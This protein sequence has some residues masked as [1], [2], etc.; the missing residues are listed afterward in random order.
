MSTDATLSDSYFG[1]RPRR[2]P[3]TL[4]LDVFSSVPLGIVLMA[5]L[6]MYC[7]IGSAGI[8]YPALGPGRW[9]PFNPDVW[10]HEMPRQWRGLELTEFEWFHTPLFNALILLICLNVIITTFRRIRLNALTAGVWM[11]HSGVVILAIGS[12]I[13]FGTKF[14]GDAPV[15]RHEVLIDVPGAPHTSLIAVPGNATHVATDAGEYEFAVASIDPAWE[16]RSESDLGKKAW[17]VMVR[18]RT[19]SAEFIRQLLAG[20]PQ[21]T[22]DVLPGRGRVKK[23]E[24]F[25]GRALVDES[26]A[27]SLGTPPQR[28]FWVKDSAAVMARDAGTLEWSQRVIH[29]LPRYNDRIA[30]MGDAWPGEDVPRPDVLDL[31][32]PGA[33][34]VLD[35]VDVR[36][37][38]YLRYAVMRSGF[39]P[40]GPVKNPVAEVRLIT[41]DGQE[42][43]ETLVAFDESRRSAFGGRM[44]FD[45]IEDPMV[46][47][48]YLDA[49]PRELILRIPDASFEQVVPFRLQDLAAAD[50][51]TVLLGETGWQYRIDKATDRLPLANGQSVTL[52]LVEFINPEGQRF[53]RWVFEDASRNRDIHPTAVEEP[54]TPALPDARLESFY[55]PGRMLSTISLVAAP[56][57]AGLHVFFDEGQGGRK[58]VTLKPGESAPVTFGVTLT[59]KRLL[60]DGME[61][62]RPMIVPRRQRDRDADA[63]QAYSLV[64]VELSK[65]GW[66][67]ARWIPFH[68][69]TFDEP[70]DPVGVLSRFEPARFT[71]PT[72]RTVEIMVGR[73]RRDLPHPVRLDDFVLT[74]HVGGFTGRVSSVR[75]WTSV[76]RFETGGA[77]SEPVRVSTNDPGMHE[78]IWFFQSFWD[79]PRAAQFEGDAPS[80]GMA[81]TGLGVGNR[82]GVYIQLFGCCLSVAGMLY[83]FYVKPIIRRRRRAHVLAE[84]EAGRLGRRPYAA[85]LDDTPIRFNGIADGD[86]TEHHR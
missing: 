33:G 60:V 85:S 58:A 6:F 46:L 10:R 14:E 71:L 30:S 57:H 9:N 77:W 42:F 19:P 67:D 13:Y 49:G 21:Y 59:L 32:V 51:P 86:P 50:R 27:L 56:D 75:D 37:T 82:R 2:G 76:I 74:P 11:I 29:H 61:E 47:P 80:A 18:V 8:L 35:G 84:V 66:R 28:R 23:I 36:L 78:G 1:P 45:W 48:Q 4:V 68:R 17:S 3:V 55:R 5:I 22:E 64:R 15:F 26:I 31:A 44:T 43:N 39:V 53:T 63:V 41:P 83:A 62:T 24:E 25:G 34:D 12:Y 65:D 72:G 40:S 79:P 52:L 16:L 20:Y 81:F 73:E 38:G 69:Y 54:H 7:T 70:I